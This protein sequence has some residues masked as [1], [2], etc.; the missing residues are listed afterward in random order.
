MTMFA[1]AAPLE[2]NAAKAIRDEGFPHTFALMMIDRRR[3]A[4]D[5]KAKIGVPI[6]GLKH[7]VFVECTEPEVHHIKRK[8][9][10]AWPVVHANGKCYPVAERQRQMLWNKRALYLFPG[11]ALLHDTDQDQAIAIE[12]LRKETPAVRKGDR[13]EFS[14]LNRQIRTDVLNTRLETAQDGPTLFLKL[15]VMGKLL[16]LPADEVAVM[17]DAQRQAA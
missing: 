2:L 14:L 8:V 12:K 7:Y 15:E 11:H 16:W 10:T 3:I 9:A 13:V 5:S 6:R 4:R 17:A 1:F